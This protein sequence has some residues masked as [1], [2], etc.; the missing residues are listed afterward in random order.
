VRVHPTFKTKIMHTGIDIRA[1]RGVPVRAAGPGE[2]LY[3]GWLR[4][5]GQVVIVDHGNSL[6]T[7]YAH[8]SSSVVEEGMPV[9]EGQT[10]GAVGSSGTA[11]GAHLHFEVRVNGDARDPLAYLRR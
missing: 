5:Y 11:T 1:E 2:V 4:G 9:K 7:V 6:T 10:I 3:S 8:L